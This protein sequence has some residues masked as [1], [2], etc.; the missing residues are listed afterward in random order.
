MIE[1]RK[2]TTP[3]PYPGEVYQLWVVH[4]QPDGTVG[5]T[6]TVHKTPMDALVALAAD[7]KE[8][9]GFGW[10]EAECTRFEGRDRKEMQ[11]RLEVK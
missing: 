2:K 1:E 10:Y 8:D 7:T 11:W 6:V 5:N 3:D 9:G 4:Q